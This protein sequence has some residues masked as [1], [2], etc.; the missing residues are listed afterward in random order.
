MTTAADEG[1]GGAQTVRR[2]LALLRLVACGQERGVRLVDLE[3]MSGLNRPTVHRLL[4]TLIQE[5]AVEQDA[6][7][8][9]YLIGPEVSLLG[10]A[11]TRR[12]PLLT[13]AEPYL[14]ELADQVGDTVFLSIRHGHDSICIGRCTGHHPIQVLSIEVGVR[15]PLG[16]GVS[17]VALLA[18]LDPALSRVL[19]EDNAARLGVLGERVDDILA[20]VEQARERG[21]AHAPA[22]LMPGT[23]AVALPILTPAGEA[24]GAVTVTA[25]AERLA[26][27][28]F[29][30]VTARMRE[31]AA[32]IAARHAQLAQASAKRVTA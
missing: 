27:Q 17:G 10:L 18:N 7:T 9:R 24:L 30:M 25:M 1:A 14:A 31:T 26:P 4:K 8:R 16:V 22:G 23:S 12:F 32:A 13:L 29:G 15:R 21:L 20:R 6:A 19:V 2:A 11:R 28:R 5:G 3:R